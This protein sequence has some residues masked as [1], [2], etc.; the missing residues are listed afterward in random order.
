MSPLE[1]AAQAYEQE[2]RLW[3]I[4]YDTVNKSSHVLRGDESMGELLYDNGGA[5]LYAME[6][7]RSHEGMREALLILAEWL[8]PEAKQQ[9]LQLVESEG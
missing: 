7:L 5:A 2:R 6:R 4:R 8:P 3:R 9:L 1:A